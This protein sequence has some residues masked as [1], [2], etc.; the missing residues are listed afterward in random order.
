MKPKAYSASEICNCSLRLAFSGLSHLRYSW[1]VSLPTAF[2]ETSMFL[3][4]RG[5]LTCHLQ[6]P[7]TSF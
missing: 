5:M 4:K 2:Q 1:K 7:S 6:E 3:I